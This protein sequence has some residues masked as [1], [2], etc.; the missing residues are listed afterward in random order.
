[1]LYFAVNHRWTRYDFYQLILA[2]LGLE[3]D[4][5]QGAMTRIMCL[6][7]CRLGDVNCR[8]DITITK[9]CGPALAKSRDFH[10]SWW[11]I[12]PS[13]LKVSRDAGIC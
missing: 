13:R 10:F 3:I 7:W 4:V 12:D 5:L 9:W 6:L 1:M 11:L 8:V 2:R